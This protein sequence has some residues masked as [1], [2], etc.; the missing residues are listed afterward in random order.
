MATTS[1]TSG[2]TSSASL[3]A[4]PAAINSRVADREA[5][6]RR[7]QLW[8]GESRP[9]KL[10]PPTTLMDSVSSAKRNE[11]GAGATAAPISD[12]LDAAVDGREAS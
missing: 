8:V 1:R 10:G 9:L 2:G 4:P 6:G 12:C 5:I 7:I 11:S 3:A